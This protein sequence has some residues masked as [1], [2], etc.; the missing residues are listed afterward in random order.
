MRMDYS[1]IEGRFIF[2][3]VWKTSYNNR[4]LRYTTICHP[5]DTQVSGR[6][7]SWSPEITGG[8]G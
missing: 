5:P 8:L 4:L 6:P 2:P 3:I 7:M 1:C